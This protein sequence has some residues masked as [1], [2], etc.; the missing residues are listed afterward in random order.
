MDRQELF[1]KVEA[2]G[3][4]L[5]DTALFLDSHPTNRMALDFFRDNQA[6]YMQYRD[7]YE[8][9][10]GP[11]TFYGVDTSQGWTWTQGPWPWEVE[12]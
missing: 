2:V 6:M 7:E 5:Y 9:N 8:K 12:A 1:N 10:Y 3:F 4:A 11:L